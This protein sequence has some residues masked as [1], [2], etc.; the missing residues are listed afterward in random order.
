[1]TYEESIADLRKRGLMEEPQPQGGI[2]PVAGAFAGSAMDAAAD[3]VL[4]PFDVAIDY[5]GRALM[6]DDPEASPVRAAIAEKI[7]RYN[8]AGMLR[9]YAKEQ[10]APMLADVP[11]RQ[12]DPNAGILDYVLDPYV[13]AS[14]MGSMVG[15]MGSSAVSPIG[16]IG[17][18]LSRVPQAARF[19]NSVAGRGLSAMRGGASEGLAEGV[20]VYDDVTARGG[21]ANE[22]IA[23]ALKTAGLNI[24]IDVLTN[25]L[26]YAAENRLAKDAITATLNKLTGGKLSAAAIERGANII[27]QGLSGTLSEGGQETL[28]STVSKKY[29]E[30]RT[31]G[32]VFSPETLRET[33]VT[34]GLPGA[35][36]GGVTGGAF[37]SLRPVQPNGK[38]TAQQAEPQPQLA[39][40]QAPD[41]A[42]AQRLAQAQAA[43]TD[44]TGQPRAQNQPSSAQ[45]GA[46]DTLIDEIISE[47][48]AAQETAAQTG[49]SQEATARGNA[50]VVA[51]AVNS[52]PLE[53]L[54][55]AR[56]REPIQAAA[57]TQP[58]ESVT[59]KQY[60]QAAQPVAPQSQPGNFVRFRSNGQLMQTPVDYALMEID[61]LVTSNL[62]S[63]G[64][65]PAYPA[66]FQPRDRSRASGMLQVSQ[67]ARDLRPELLG[68]DEYADRGAPIIDA[69]GNVISGNGRTMSIRSAYRNQ[70]DTS[71]ARYRS[72]LSEN[73]AALGLDGNA[74]RSMRNPVLV[75]RL[76]DPQLDLRAFAEDANTPVVAGMSA[77]EQAMKDAERLTPEILAKFVPNDTGD[78]LTNN[79]EFVQAFG[80]GVVDRSEMERF[81]NREGRLSQDG[82]RRIKNAL[83]A[84]A[85]GDSGFLERVSESTD[86]DMRNLS[87]ALT[88]AAPAIASAEEKMSRGLLDSNLSLRAPLIEAVRELERVREQGGN[89]A[90][91]LNQ[92]GLFG[93]QLSDEAKIL[94]QFFDAN[95][96]SAKAIRTL[97]TDYAATVEEKGDPRQASMFDAEGETASQLLA[98]MAARQGKGADGRAIQAAG[99]QGRLDFNAPEEPTAQVQRDEAVPV[100]ATPAP[101]APQTAAAYPIENARKAYTTAGE[102]RENIEYS[103]DEESDGSF[104][105]SKITSTRDENG[106]I[107]ATRREVIENGLDEREAEELRTRLQAEKATPPPTSQQ[108]TNRRADDKDASA[109]AAPAPLASEPAPPQMRLAARVFDMLKKGEKIKDNVAFAR[110]ADEAWGG[111][112]AQGAYDMSQAYDALEMGVNMYIRDK[113]IVPSRYA[114]AASIKK[115]VAALKE[116]VMDKLP[117]MSNRSE[118]KMQFQQFS[119]PPN[120][121]AVA[122]WL[123]GTKEG[124]VVLEPSAGLG[125]L[126][127]FAKN[128]GATVYVNELDPQRAALL[129]RMGFDGVFTENAEQIDNV[130][131]DNIRPNRIIMNP[132]FSSS[133]G[134]TSR[135]DTMNAAQHIEQALE[136]LADGGRAV[137]ILGKGM[138]DEA[139]RFKAFWD[140]IKERYNVRANVELS[141][142]DYAKY[143]TTWG[144]VI[145]VVDKTG[146]TSSTGGKRK[147]YATITGDG[148]TVSL[149]EAIDL[150]EGVA[151]DGRNLERRTDAAGRAEQSGRGQSVVGNRQAEDNR[152]HGGQSAPDA[153]GVSGGGLVGNTAV[154]S[155]R[156]QAGV[157]TVRESRPDRPDSERPAAAVERGRTKTRGSSTGRLPVGESGRGSVSEGE[158]PAASNGNGG[159]GGSGGHA[160]AGGGGVHAARPDDGHNEGLAPESVQLKSKED[161]I[162][163]Q[164]KAKPDAKNDE[165]IFE[166]YVSAVSG[167]E[168][169]ADLDEPAAMAAVQP[170]DITVK[171]SLPENIIKEGKLSAPQIEAVARAAQSFEAKN[172]DGTRRGFFIGDGTGVGKGREI[173]GI[174]TDQ[175]AK[176]H[177]NGKAL[178][179]SVK[180]DLANDARRDWEGL[181]NNGKDVI[182]H[183]KFSGKKQLEAGQKGVLFSAYSF[184]GKT[185]KRDR[186]KEIK[187]W[188][189]KDFD[190]VIALDEAH[191][192]NNVLDMKGTRGKKEAA[193]SALAVRDLI[194]SFPNARVVYVSATGA[195]EIQNLAMLERLGLWGEGTAFPTLNDFL[196]KIGN[197]GM[198]SLELV[199]RDMK[200]MGL[201][202]ARSLSFRAGKNGGDENVTF[203]RLEHKLTDQ[204][205]AVYNEIS[206]AWAVTLQHVHKAVEATKAK[207][208]QTG[209][210]Q[211]YS[212]MQACFNQILTSMSIP[213]VI[214]SIEQDLKNGNSVVIQLTNTNEAAQNRA[215][216]KL[217]KEEGDTVDDLDVTPRDALISFLENSFPVQQYEEYEDD[218][219]N[220]QT[221]PVVDSQGNPVLNKKA[222]AARDELIEH[223]R[224]IRFPDS[225]MDMIIKHF[226]VKNVAEVTGRSKTPNYEHRG[227]A[228]L[229]PRGKNANQAEMEAFQDGRKRVLIFSDAGGTGFSFHADKTK[230]NQ[231]KRIHYMLQPGWNAAK[232]VQGLGRTNRSNQA[233]KPHVILVTTDVP[234][235][236]RF[237][238]TI[239]RRLEQLG[240]LTQGDR[241]AQ[242][243]GLFNEGDNLEGRQSQ[244]AV[245]R[246]IPMLSKDILEAMNIK[247]Q[248]DRRGRPEE[249]PVSQFLNR[250]LAL[251][252]DAQRHV[253]G[254]FG[255]IQNEEIEKARANGTLD[256]G[257]RTLRADS[258]VVAEDSVV[259]KNGG[260]ETRYVKLDAGYKQSPRAFDSRAESGFIGYYNQR[261]ANGGKGRVVQVYEKASETDP[262][263]G[264]ILKT[265][266]LRGV[267]PSFSAT[268]NERTLNNSDRYAKLSKTDAEKLWNDESRELPRMRHETRHLLSGAILP[269]YNSV[270]MGEG[271]GTVLKANL[272][273]GRSVLGLAV[274]DQ[275]IGPTLRNLAAMPDNSAPRREGTAPSL[276]PED[277]IDDVMENGTEY[278]LQNGWRIKRSRVLGGNRVE[279]VGP[280]FTQER[281]VMMWGVIKDIINS[282]PRYFIPTGRPQTL[283][284]VLRSSPVD[285]D[286]TVRNNGGEERYRIAD[287]RQRDAA[288][289]NEMLRGKPVA[290]LTGEEFAKRP[291][292]SLAERVAEYFHREY[293]G[294]VERKG[295]GRILL[296]RRSVRNDILHG[297]GR[298][299]AISFAAVPD[300]LTKGRMLRY[301]PNWKGR[302][303]GTYAIGA[304]IEIANAR[305]LAIAI[306]NEADDA[307][308]GSKHGEFYLHEV[309][310]QD[311]P[312]DAS[313][314]PS[315]QAYRDAGVV[316]AAT[317]AG[318]AAHVHRSSDGPIAASA[319]AVQLPRGDSS[320]NGNVSRGDIYTL[321]NKVINVN[322]LP[323]IT[324]EAINAN[325]PGL[326][327]TRLS[328]G[329]LLLEGKGGAK[330][331]VDNRDEPL[332]INSE[333]FRQE[334]GRD[335]T[336]DD[337]ATGRTII[338]DKKAFI[339]LVNGVSTLED[340]HEELYHS[341]EGLVLRPEE[342]VKL[343][344][345]FGSEKATVEAYL[346]FRNRRM[347]RLTVRSMRFFQR[348]K[349]CFDRIRATLFGPRS[350]DI[351]RDIAD[352]RVWNREVIGSNEAVE[353]YRVSAEGNR[354]APEQGRVLEDAQEVSEEMKEAKKEVSMPAI[355]GKELEDVAKAEN[356]GRMEGMIDPLA[357]GKRR[358]TFKELMD[359][360]Y[361]AHVDDLHPILTHFGKDMHRRAANALY[362]IGSKAQYR[363][364]YGDPDRGAKGLKQI[365]EMLPAG[366]RS[367]FSYYAV[368][369]HLYDIAKL[370]ADTRAQIAGLQQQLDEGG[371]DAKGRERVEARI[372]ELKK[373]ERFTMASP[374]VYEKAIKKIEAAFPKWIEAQ[375]ELVKYNQAL[376]KML[377]NSGIISHDLYY[378]LVHRYPNYVP[379]QRDFGTEEG[380]SKFVE[381][382]GLV[383]VQNP[384]KRLR[385]SERDVIDPLDQII[386]NTY[387]FESVAA[388]QGVAREIV[389]RYD[390]GEYDGLMEQVEDR[391]HAPGES[392][393]YV[394][395]NGEKRLFKTDKDI[396]EALVRSVGASPQESNLLTKMLSAPTRALRY[397][398]THSLTFGVG[399]LMRDTFSY[400][401]LGKDFR[402]VVDTVNGF[403]AL[404]TNEELVRDFMRNGGLQESSW[405]SD[406]KREELIRLLKGRKTWKDNAAL[407]YNPISLY[408]KL[409]G[410]F[411]EV[412]EQASRLGQYKRLLDKGY[413]KEDAIFET[414][415]N[416]NFMRA[417]NVG[418]SLNRFVP[419]YNASLQ[420]VD[421]LCRTMYHDEKWDKKALARGLMYL[422][423]LSL[424]SCLYNY[425]DDDRREKYMNL[426][427]WRK[428]MFWNF[429]IGDEVFS[430][431]KPFEAGMLFGSLPERFMDYLWQH[432]K[433]AF[434]GVAQSLYGSLTPEFV[435]MAVSVMFELE[436]NYSRFFGRQIVPM[437]EQRL[438]PE[439]QY[440]P[441]TAEWAKQMTQI[442]KYLPEFA[443]VPFFENF[444]K[445]LRSPRMLEYAALALTGSAGRDLSDIYNM[446][447]RLFKGEARPSENPLVVMPGVRRLFADAKY[448]GRDQDAFRTEITQLKNKLDSATHLYKNG[449]YSAL[450]PYRVRLLQLEPVIKYTNKILTDRNRGINAANRTIQRITIAPNMTAKQKREAIDQINAYVLAMSREGLRRVEEIQ[451]YLRTDKM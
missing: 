303:Y 191:T 101:S 417:G 67:M 42:Q 197:G 232:A 110:M 70:P 161:I 333:A 211:F 286:R 19:M 407:N 108:A 295:F 390:N 127:V 260:I 81:I 189:G 389:K 170:P 279:L 265:Y 103:A 21:G 175:L 377:E 105:V 382:R 30:G 281:A 352:G 212:S 274:S 266:S 106:V 427:P 205:K 354:R 203:S 223:I 90:E 245:N 431:P 368:L 129:S 339:D 158:R 428:N 258:L 285:P 434:D 31:W 24:P 336:P 259:Y 133:A 150:L 74:V 364:L 163:E 391:H 220:K 137:M 123:L 227:N 1:M 104:S 69:R 305:Y 367:G 225:P 164:A 263:T 4:G 102:T 429:V 393:F 369:K 80:D 375:K 53:G 244:I 317:K 126:A 56:T 89:V 146:P 384:L 17:R 11:Q 314:V 296:N 315:Q 262:R 132:P 121:S 445:T 141:G 5:A 304:P 35:V 179:L 160:G 49:S 217:D 318:E 58:Q 73:A 302:G 88:Q 357:K 54:E 142:K 125:G 328:G 97:L 251:D 230:K 443:G 233:H 51:D 356:G 187:D 307:N 419:F 226:S 112:Q 401:V 43:Q 145:V 347:K 98:R 71:G 29:G 118:R 14:G 301:A 130:L 332:S 222:V 327:A 87:N 93:E 395:E 298:M 63:G 184:F 300:V 33:F 228:I 312:P 319:E 343:R 412:S 173:A 444:S 22:A 350:E 398:T 180:H 277:I 44:A 177:G 20:G 403:M 178:W 331:F 124:D 334:Y 221:R 100:T 250:V 155:E 168:H 119:T 213:S 59:L 66:E 299:K 202:L 214:S 113:Q 15:Y 122:N 406:N 86:D 13:L 16:L 240:A 271:G 310:L 373:R 255:R 78:V 359:A 216:E 269:I 159:D 138:A 413:S 415:D 34:E 425:G 324:P 224:S 440:G 116:Q 422:T 120:Y 239:A 400:A 82:A 311:I 147:A 348:I 186:A 316:H 355:L 3:A 287:I 275:R 194:R 172:P 423:T 379:L 363:L 416:M 243:K 237:T 306:V 196:T 27:S 441:H 85:Y 167:K 77:S 345:D 152:L 199:A 157:Q 414:R 91:V 218:N 360:A 193:K 219:G 46:P 72:W 210:S 162:K 278:R 169:P 208:K 372:A 247:P 79:G 424:A 76:T 23:A 200:A 361:T 448:G 114:T 182:Q 290:R 248:T 340:F 8:P 238:S 297:I 151:K 236:R 264:E 39:Q 256:T 261:T 215:A 346:N 235:Q 337:I 432:D 282:K 32:D 321:L 322:S 48:N 433:R 18:G 399:N 421:K 408:F 246:L 289:K 404:I 40:P 64:V 92:Q 176:G 330:I 28:Q 387:A 254:I 342:I 392:I 396:Y 253:F 174:I 156:G 351:F 341:A 374:E 192:V 349:D 154:D 2:A 323:E 68:A 183:S 447:S 62:D 325:A 26:G 107:V 335:V 402:P 426:R 12:Y 153:D 449:E 385:G 437:S 84:K 383:N 442:T 291:G 111:T 134:R 241:S 326:H 37:G 99:D 288:L 50:E 380:L 405:L 309:M 451:K 229:V 190:G 75:R 420:G 320:S 206:R 276:A 207:G 268:I 115:S 61:D 308:A 231:Q 83:V 36:V 9:D 234:G 362:G 446:G 6:P 344:E 292:E 242:N 284:M 60:G 378:D 270:E 435:P 47:V 273:D 294:A 135:N 376:L 388:R 96:R 410:A 181:G 45:S 25:Y 7:Q 365:W 409:S 128:A 117:T 366:H 198:A 272:D 358:R 41:A 397:G 65:N 411:A 293:G 370:T 394:Y 439:L 386:R 252:I 149:D 338:M 131:P 57:R 188:L 166:H 143:G 148:K 353:R 171:L 55:K 381:G 95:K 165:T 450:T 283:A 280:D 201:Y 109:P 94:L 249:V 185:G 329:A 144:N 139:P 438:D 209:Y 267:N 436:A 10:S 52:A 38:E 430:I 371:L 195:T 140:D 313:E 136:R 257:T 204:Q 418:R